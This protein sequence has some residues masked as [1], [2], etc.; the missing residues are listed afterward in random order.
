MSLMKPKNI[1]PKTDKEARENSY[2]APRII[3]SWQIMVRAIGSTPPVT[4]P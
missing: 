2:E 4:P 3:K 1:A